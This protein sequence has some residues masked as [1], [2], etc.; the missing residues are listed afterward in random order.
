MDEIEVGNVYELTDD[1]T[2]KAAEYEVVGLA[3]LSGKQYA[4]I[5]P[6]GEEV[7]EYV[8]LRIESD[9]ENLMFVAIED[10]DEWETAAVYFDDTIFGV[11]DHDETGE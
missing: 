10:D 1:E 3:E 11:V 8:I 2:G 6:Y 7:E 9:S 4:A 5:V